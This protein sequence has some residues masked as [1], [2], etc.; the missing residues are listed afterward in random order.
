MRRTVLHMQAA[1]DAA[2]DSIAWRAQLHLSARTHLHMQ[3]C[4]PLCKT[5]LAV[6]A[7]GRQNT[8]WQS[9]GHDCIAKVSGADSIAWRT[10]LHMTPAPH[11]K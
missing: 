7:P 1:A 6:N 4:P 9:P 8:V 2:A 11:E 5:A 10:Q 3:L